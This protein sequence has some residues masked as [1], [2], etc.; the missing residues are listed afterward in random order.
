M[1]LSHLLDGNVESL[2]RVSRV[3]TGFRENTG[4]PGDKEVQAKGTSVE[5]GLCTKGM[6][7]SLSGGI[8]MSWMSDD[9]QTFVNSL[10]GP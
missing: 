9:K 1:G 3:R 4:G 5:A 10:Q 2:H 7:T 8:M 6:S